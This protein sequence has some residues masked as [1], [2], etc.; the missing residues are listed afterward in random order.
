VPTR[1]RGGAA[2]APGA[3]TG[4]GD[5]AAAAATD[6]IVNVAGDADCGRWIKAGVAAFTSLKF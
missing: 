1:P 2:D 3:A 4:T 6:D 5:E